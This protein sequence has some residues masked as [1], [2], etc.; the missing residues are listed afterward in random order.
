V[1]RNIQLD[2]DIEVEDKEV[3]WD[4]EEVLDSYIIEG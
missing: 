2:K 4:I 1:P 3:E